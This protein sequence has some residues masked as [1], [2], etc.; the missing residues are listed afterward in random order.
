MGY[1]K[2]KCTAYFQ[3]T[4]RDPLLN[5]IGIGNLTGWSLSHVAFYFLLGHMFP[6]DFKL[7]MLLG[8]I[9]ELLE[10]YVFGAFD[11]AKTNCTDD[12]WYGEV[13]DL[14]MNAIGFWLGCALNK[15][16]DRP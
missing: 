6:K 7:L 14:F 8:V 12:F 16:I 10:Q 9:W 5:K 1:A 13:S 2:L 3:K 11:L 4:R 15:Y